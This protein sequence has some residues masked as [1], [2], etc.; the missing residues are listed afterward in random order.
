MT[1]SI[2]PFIQEQIPKYILEGDSLFPDFL[3]AYYEWLSLSGNVQGETY[4]LDAINNVDE[5]YDLFM[6]E[7]TDEYL[8]NIPND[9]V[10]DKTLLIKKIT[11]LYKAK[12]TPKAVQFLIKILHNVDSSVFLPSTEIFK[13]SNAKWNRDMSV[14]FV[15]SSGSITSFGQMPCTIKSENKNYSTIILKII[16]VDGET[17]V[18]EAFIDA[19]Y[20]ILVDNAGQIETDTFVGSLVPTI[21]S[22]NIIDGGKYFIVGDIYDVSGGNGTGMK[23]KVTNVSTKSALK[24]FQIIKFG[25]N[26]TQ[27]FTLDLIPQSGA[28]KNQVDIG[29]NSPNATIEFKLG[30]VLEYPGYYS[31]NDGFPSDTSFLH[32]GEYYQQFSYV[33]KSGIQYDKYSSSVDKLVHPSGTNKFGEYYVNDNIPLQVII[34]SILSAVI[35][36]IQD[37]IGATDTISFSMNKIQLENA[38]AHDSVALHLYKVINDNVTTFDT[39]LASILQ[40]GTYNDSSNISDIISINNAKVLQENVSITESTQI[41]N[42]KV[43]N[44]TLDFSETFSKSFFKVLID[45]VYT[46]D[47]VDNISVVSSATLTATTTQS[48]LTQI[49]LTSLGGETYHIY[50]TSLASPPIYKNNSNRKI[51]VVELNTTNASSP[52][53]EQKIGRK[54]IASD[55]YIESLVDFSTFPLTQSATLPSGWFTDNPSGFVEIVTTTSRGISGAT[56]NI[57]DLERLSG[58]TQNIYSNISSISG[59]T[60]N[61]RF[62]YSARSGFS[63]SDCAINILVNGAVFAS[64]SSAVVGFVDYEYNIPS[65]GSSMRIELKSQ[66]T[67]GAGALIDKISIKNIGYRERDINSRIAYFGGTGTLVDG[68]VIT[69]PAS[70]IERTARIFVMAYST[71]TN[72]KFKTE[73]SLSDNSATPIVHN[74]VCPT[75]QDVFY[76]IN[77]TYKASNDN[78]TCQVIWKFEQSSTVSDTQ[79]VFYL[80]SWV[81]DG[82]VAPIPPELSVTNIAQ[83]QVSTPDINMTSLGGGDYYVV[84]NT[85]ANY[86][87]VNNTVLETAHRK[88]AGG[89]TISVQTSGAGN[90]DFELKEKSF[91][92]TDGTPVAS[93]NSNDYYARMVGY[94]STTPIAG[95]SINL[96]AG[97]GLR[98]AKLYL[99]GFNN[100]ANGNMFQLELSLSDNSVTPIVST[101]NNTTAGDVYYTID[102]S[103]RASSENQIC[104]VKWL[105]K[106]SN[107][108]RA[109]FVGA[110]WV[111]LPS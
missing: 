106:N 111:G 69:L 81:N 77:V 38:I 31:T 14:R 56:Y 40:T 47:V 18:Y 83:T 103:Y 87:V 99:M 1:K 75:S 8:E 49:N 25:S 72:N 61:L 89:S 34:K 27:D 7:F 28:I 84:R 37:F 45:S 85:G 57:L 78:T 66:T 93:F 74:I 108:L 60:I 101:I 16:K 63:A 5:S 20:K 68:Y 80:G 97:S 59:G 3:E 104:N 23:I 15:V 22:K 6:Q 30:Y 92:G 53:N 26:F 102:I 71:N 48:A 79:A 54:L 51:N 64:I 44:D 36:S 110:I 86:S 9:V 12:G 11:E 29:D 109:V 52:S 73:I 42:L 90:F 96:P 88:N 67:D 107:S 95:Y 94:N 58:N 65:T 91:T 32:D 35:S 62:G 46:S 19:N 100:T 33:V 105:A 82:T 50:D 21:T 76:E 17:D 41:S 13:A 70:T 10:V 4:K 24:S 43:L 55:S 2:T 39:A 98:T